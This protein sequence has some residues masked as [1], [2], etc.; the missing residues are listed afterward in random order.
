LSNGRLARSGSALRC[1]SARAA[2]KPPTPIGVMAASDPPA[3]ITSASPRLM[4]SNASPMACASSTFE[5]L[6][7]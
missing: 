7:K 6:W 1:E 4:I 5:R 3:I 2:P